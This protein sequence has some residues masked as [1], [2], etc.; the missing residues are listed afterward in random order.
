MSDEAKTSTDPFV[1]IEIEF[2]DSTALSIDC[3]LQIGER[4]T[5]YEQTAFTNGLL[6][7]D[8]WFVVSDIHNEVYAIPI[9]QIKTIACRT[10][11]SDAT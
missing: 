10:I 2:A 1:E 8:G 5:T 6:V 3:P 4:Y 7:K 9:G 11:K